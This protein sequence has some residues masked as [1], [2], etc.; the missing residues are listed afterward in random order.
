LN[1][2]LFT[3]KKFEIEIKGVF[4]DYFYYIKRLFLQA[5]LTFKKPDPFNP[6]FFAY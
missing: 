6:I 1:D 2:P 4:I 5:H 3:P